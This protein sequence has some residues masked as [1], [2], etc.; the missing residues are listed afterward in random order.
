MNMDS[1]NFSPPDGL[2]G[3]A[4]DAYYAGMSAASILMSVVF[5][6]VTESQQRLARGVTELEGN[7]PP[8][9]SD[10]CSG[11]ADR[12][13]N[14]WA[15]Q[16]REFSSLPRLALWL[17]ASEYAKSRHGKDNGEG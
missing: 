5:R 12:A 15:R 1:S 6:Q 14:E 11:L 8:D 3:N 17:Y 13:A 2:L 10:V 7:A 4:R 16:F 9:L